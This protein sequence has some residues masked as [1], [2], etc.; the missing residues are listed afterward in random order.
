MAKAGR[1][2]AGVATVGILLLSGRLSRADE[3]PTVAVSVTNLADVTPADLR[4][5]ERHVANVYETIAVRV[6]W[7]SAGPE[8][9]TQIGGP[10]KVHLMLLAR[11]EADHVALNGKHDTLGLSVA[12]SRLAYV[13]SNRVLMASLTRGMSFAD[14]LGH[15]MAHELGHLLLP[16]KGHTA[17]GLMCASVLCPANERSFS[18]PQGTAIRALLN[19]ALNWSDADLARELWARMRKG[20]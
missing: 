8:V 1:T 18:E 3:G 13:F 6:E 17:A 7:V 4:A 5:A 15:V 16:G 10:L 11:K 20:K 14:G 2:L 12:P 9:A 19:A